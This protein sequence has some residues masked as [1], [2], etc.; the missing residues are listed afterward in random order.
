MGITNFKKY[1]CFVEYDKNT[2]KINKEIIAMED[3]DGTWYEDHQFFE[4][5][6]TDYK[7]YIS[8]E[9]YNLSTLR[10]HFTPIES[11]C[12]FCNLSSLEDVLNTFRRNDDVVILK[13]IVLFNT[14]FLNGL[15]Q[16]NTSV[17]LENTERHKYMEIMFLEA[18]MQTSFYIDMVHCF[19]TDDVEELHLHEDAKYYVPPQNVNISFTSD[20]QQLN[21]TVERNYEIYGVVIKSGDIEFGI[22]NYVEEKVNY[23]YNH[24]LLWN[25]NNFV[26]LCSKNEFLLNLQ[27]KEI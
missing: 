15:Y 16:R 6:H 8:S 13:G 9:F 26:N 10:R 21:D 22:Y 23:K 3:G 1:D 20:L 7:K 2:G 19:V 18:N 4:F 17:I 24:G 25:E 11:D 12:G 27:K 5:N 14:L